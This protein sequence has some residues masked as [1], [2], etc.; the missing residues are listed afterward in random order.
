MAEDW[1]KIRWEQLNHRSRSYSA[2]L[3]YIPFAYVGIVGFAFD[4]I[5]SLSPPLNSLGII[6]LGIFSIA[7][8][9]HVLALKFYERRAVRSMQEL[10]KDNV[11][12]SGGSHW[13]LSFAWYI[14]YMICLASYFFIGYGFYLFEIPQTCLKILLIVVILLI[15]TILYVY[16][17]WQDY[18]RNHP[19]VSDIRN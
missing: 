9:V 6:L 18:K 4:K 2:Q 8:L 13:Y 17:F 16:I 15:L 5:A 19:L 7:V 11:I 1:D 3:W 12:S 10:E 14:K